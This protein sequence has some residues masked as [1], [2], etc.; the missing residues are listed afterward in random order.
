MHAHPPLTN[1]A[2]YLDILSAALSFYLV[3]GVT[4]TKNLDIYFNVVKIQD[5]YNYFHQDTQ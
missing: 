3:I 4:C 1:L 5:F 2:I